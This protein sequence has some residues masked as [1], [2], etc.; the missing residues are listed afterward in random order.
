MLS[1]ESYALARKPSRRRPLRRRWV[2]LR[3]RVRRFTIIHSNPGQ[4]RGLSGGI[5]RGLSWLS[6]LFSAVWR[7]ITGLLSWIYRWCCRTAE[8]AALR[9]RD[10]DAVRWDWYQRRL[11]LK[12]LTQRRQRSRTAP[13]LLMAS[14]VVMIVSACCFSLGFEVRLNGESIGYVENR[15][16][17]L[18]VVEQVEQRVSS[19]LG[20]PYSLDADFS[21]SLRY[22]DRT[23]RL[24]QELLAQRLFASVDDQPHRYVLLVDGEIL[25]SCQSRTAL[26]LMLRRILLSAVPNATQVNTSFVNDVQIQETTSQAVP[27][28][29]IADME[30]LLTSLKE[31][32]QYYTVQPGD[33]VSA[34][35]LNHDTTVSQVKALNPGLDETRIYSGQQITLS[36]AVPYLSVQQTVTETYA[37]TIPFQ[38]NV[39]YDDSMYKNKSY[40][41]VEGVNG[42]ADVV[43]D[44]TY[45]NG[46][47]TNR[48]ILSYTVTREPVNAV[49]V[50]G[51]KDLPRTA[52]TGSFIKPSNGRFTSGYGYRPS[53]GDFHTGVDFAG[54]TGTAI[55]AADGG[56][57]SFAG[58]K[59]N[60][61]LCVMI[62]H[63]NGY[64]TLYAHC[65]KLLVS[66]G[67]KVAKGD[68]IAKVGA[69]GR[70]T[71][72]HVH[73]EIKYNGA[74]QNPLK[75]IGK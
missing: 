73:F 22:M 13:A 62:D 37:E 36:G 47:E 10:F 1:A 38:T 63:G 65:S 72:A 6:G 8:Q 5:F 46:S 45:V 67:D 32:T 2:K 3:M 33:T 40:I 31:E 29:T 41:K 64:V 52:A 66:K 4:I 75:Y 74:N 49:K 69:T 18:Q 58:R 44:V 30:A 26:E 24:D 15:R 53:L 68:Q 55:W 35:A 42:S 34:I 70:V 11:E 71:G 48:N 16:E 28:A 61:G 25:G 57:V 7:A 43:A 23:E 50:V 20:A 54:K 17:V 56:T 59:G 51:T 19:Y 60:Y 27:A 12:S 21:Y 9:I 39:E 14:A